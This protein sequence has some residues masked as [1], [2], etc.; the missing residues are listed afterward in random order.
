MTYFRLSRLHE[1]YCPIVL[2][3][4]GIAVGLVDFTLNLP[5]KQVKALVENVFEEIRASC[6][7]ELSC[8]LLGYNI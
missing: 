5:D 3:L 7:I 6:E 4:V 1:Y 8:T 2:G